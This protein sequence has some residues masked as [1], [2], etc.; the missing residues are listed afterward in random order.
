[1]K[2][3]RYLCDACDKRIG[4]NIT[5]FPHEH[6]VR[7]KMVTHGYGM[8]DGEHVLSG[9]ICSPKCGLKLLKRWVREIETG[10]VQGAARPEGDE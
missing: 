1:M 6:V 7:A 2:K 8:Q 10:D 4:S 9:H 3:V 5:S